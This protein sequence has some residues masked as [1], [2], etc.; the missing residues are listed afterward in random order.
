MRW[1]GDSTVLCARL[2]E[3]AVP[4]VIYSGMP[5]LEGPCTEAPLI[6]KPANP[7]VIVEKVADLLGAG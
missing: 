2:K 1:D 4:Y 3:R 7:S 6:E 5:D